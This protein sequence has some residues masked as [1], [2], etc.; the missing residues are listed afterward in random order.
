MEILIVKMASKYNIT[1]DNKDGGSI[2]MG[3][4]NQVDI[5]AGGRV[6]KAKFYNFPCM[7]CLILVLSINT[8][9]IDALII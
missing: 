1:I 6:G 5:G 8:L 7:N 4:Q 9:Y 2:I 3:D